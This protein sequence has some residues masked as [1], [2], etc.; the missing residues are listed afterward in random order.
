[1]VTDECAP[2][3]P[4][5]KGYKCSMFEKCAPHSKI[6]N[7]GFIGQGYGDATE[8]KIMK[9]LM[10]GGAVNG[11]IKFPRLAAMYKGGIMTQKGLIKLHEDTVELAQLTNKQ[12][13][14]LDARQKSLNNFSDVT[15]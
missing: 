1:M 9:E 3:V 10:Y 13:A 7:T 15:Q 12:K 11:E 2:Y 5:T 8:K 14:R 4:S 6:V